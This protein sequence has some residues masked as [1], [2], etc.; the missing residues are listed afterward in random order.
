MPYQERRTGMAQEAKYTKVSIWD[1]IL[2]GWVEA[3]EWASDGSAD[4]WISD[5]KLHNKEADTNERFLVEIIHE[6]EVS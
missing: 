6:Y 5:R 2:G 1:D 4:K 3:G